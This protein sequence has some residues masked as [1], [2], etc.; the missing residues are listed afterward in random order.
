MYDQHHQHLYDAVRTALHDVGYTLTE[1][2]T[3]G[4]ALGTR[5]EG[6]VLTWNLGP[7]PLTP[8]TVPFTVRLC[9]SDRISATTALFLAS[10]MLTTELQNSGFTLADDIGE[11]VLVTAA[12]S[13]S[14]DRAPHR[15]RWDA[16][17]IAALREPVSEPAA[18]DR[19]RSR[20]LWWRRR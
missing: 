13:T 18:P 15:A 11:G 12:P 16:E 19:P 5:A 7:Q 9:E 2:G 6:V 8:P 3:T 1:P 10:Q 4:L 14:W 20:A 17:T